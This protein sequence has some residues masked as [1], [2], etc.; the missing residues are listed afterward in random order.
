MQYIRV[1][2]MSGVS[3]M[4]GFLEKASIS[5]LFFLS[6]SFY[7]LSAVIPL[8]FLTRE[9]FYRTSFLKPI[10]TLDGVLNRTAIHICEGWR[11][12]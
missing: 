10:M 9:L 6:L 11:Y 2:Y 12:I 4:D 5:P 8:W 7:L 3:D 1:V